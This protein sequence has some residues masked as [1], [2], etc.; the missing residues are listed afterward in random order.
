MRKKAK[1]VQKTMHTIS[2]NIDIDQLIIFNK[3][4]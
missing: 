3:P 1:N 2:K 4:I